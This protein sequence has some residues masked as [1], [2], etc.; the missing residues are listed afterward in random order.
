MQITFQAIHFTA[1]QKLKEYISEKLEKL[2]K[3]YG[4]IIETTVYLKLENS[5]Q[6]RD[7]VV[8]VKMNIPGKTLVV[9][10]I[11]KT[12]ESA[13]DDA[14]EMLKK[15]LKKNHDRENLAAR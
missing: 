15:Q 10:H 11:D 7:K 9:R 4:K 8:E 12:F 2:S 3:F 13:F 1:D 14:L 6:I 5:G